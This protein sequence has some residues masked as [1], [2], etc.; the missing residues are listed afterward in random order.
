VLEDV[1]PVFEFL[2]N[3]LKGDDFSYLALKKYLKVL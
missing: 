3:V 2:V 1:V